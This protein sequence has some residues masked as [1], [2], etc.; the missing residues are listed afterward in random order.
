MLILL[1]TFFHYEYDFC[2]YVLAMNCVV[3]NS[4]HLK[5]WIFMVFFFINQQ[6]NILISIILFFILLVVALHSFVLKGFLIFNCDHTRRE[7][8]KRKVWARTL[9][10]NTLYKK[11]AK[12]WPCMRPCESYVTHMH[13]RTTPLCWNIVF[14]KHILAI[15]YT[16]CR[17]CGK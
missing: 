1:E 7:P 4:T 9:E 11:I 3:T 17:S 10:I 6:R 14:L 16:C 12:G 2:I 5:T 13:K 8:N 15:G